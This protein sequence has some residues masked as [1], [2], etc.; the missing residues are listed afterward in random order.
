MSEETSQLAL[1]PSEAVS[2][3]TGRNRAYGNP[4]M[5]VKQLPS[6]GE[7]VIVAEI[8]PVARPRSN[9]LIFLILC[10]PCHADLQ[11]LTS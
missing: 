10:P 5:L 6:E 3:L 7:E 11:V 2:R 8:S 9:S 1:S 4:V